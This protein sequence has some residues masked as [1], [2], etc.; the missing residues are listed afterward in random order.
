MVQPHSD[1]SAA[2]APDLKNGFVVF[3]T[4]VGNAWATE[5]LCAVSEETEDRRWHY[6]SKECRSEDVAFH[7]GSAGGRIFQTER[8]WEFVM[9][10][11]D[12]RAVQMTSSDIDARHPSEERIVPITMAESF[13]A[14]VHCPLRQIRALSVAE[15]LDRLRERRLAVRDLFMRVEWAGDA[16]RC[17]IYCPCR[18]VN[19]GNDAAGR[20][21]YIQPISGYVLFPHPEAGIQIGYVAC[22]LAGDGTRVT[23]FCGK[24]YRNV[25]DW[26]LERIEAGG[27]N[28]EMLRQLSENMP[29]SATVCDRIMPVDGTC[30]VFEYLG[31]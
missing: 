13:T 27:E 6:L 15:T 22:T 20:N 5:I 28:S 26:A 18:Y 19:F 14:E 10:V 17:E 1:S 29:I 30:E 3:V 9:A 21:D 31:T 24:R 7:D 23:E 11:L 12:G 25:F 16:G 8:S 2:E 4:P